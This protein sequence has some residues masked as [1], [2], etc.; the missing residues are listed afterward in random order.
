M[1]AVLVTGGAGYIGG[2]AVLALLD[3][4]HEPVILD[5]LSRGTREAVPPGVPLVVG[6]I[7][8]R[9]LVGETL[10][11][12]GIGAV[13]HFAASIVVP[14]SVREPASY[15]RNNTCGA[16]ALVE[17]CL[18]A[19]VGPFI[20]SS[21]AAVYGSPDALPIPETAPIAPINPYGA[22]KAMVERMLQDVALARPSF[23][24][25]SLRY[26]NVAGADPKGRA[27]KR[28]DSLTHLIDL[29]V[30]TALG[31][32]PQLQVFG[33][34]YPTRDGTC[35]RDYI[36]IADLAEAHVAA[37]RYLE[38]GGEPVALNCGYGKGFTVLEVIDRLETLI[39]RK[40]PVRIAERRPG[41][42]PSL[43]ACADRIRSVLDWA[44]VREDLGDI[45]D[46]ALG[47]RRL[48]AGPGPS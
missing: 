17:A 15:Y 11:G 5:N 6:D 12:R 47:W 28:S 30:E 10:R 36:H 8:D 35:E 7:A 42:P 43:V 20:F 45:L 24:P 44:P 16:L 1:T 38:A 46:S 29:A 37:L 25:A 39:G 41:D 27:G 2:Q 48:R 19:G 18:E 9:A 31:L 33:H 26:F 22:S 4:G 13:M 3:A 14:E 21:T 40:L 23:R 34:D 32:Q